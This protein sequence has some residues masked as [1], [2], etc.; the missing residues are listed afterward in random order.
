MSESPSAKV[1]QALIELGEHESY[2]KG[3]RDVSNELKSILHKCREMIR[4]KFCHMT[5]NLSNKNPNRDMED[6]YD[7]AVTEII[8]EIMQLELTS[9][10]LRARKEVKPKETASCSSLRF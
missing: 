6:G 7:S 10:K 8:N 2:V 4:N 3:G 1:F 5:L 9:E